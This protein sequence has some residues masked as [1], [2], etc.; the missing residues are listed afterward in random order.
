[1]AEDGFPGFR[2]YGKVIS[3]SV[4]DH[5]QHP[6]R[7]PLD[8]GVRI[9]DK[10]D[11]TLFKV[12]N[13]TR[14]V[15]DGIVFYFIKKAVNCQV[16]AKGIIR[17][18]AEGVIGSQY[19]FLGSS[20]VAIKIKLTAAAKGGNFNNFSTVKKNLDQPEASADK[21]AVSENF[22]KLARSRIS[23]YIKI[24]RSFTK[25]KVTD[26]SAYQIG[27]MAFIPQPVKDFEC[28]PVYIL[29]RNG[30]A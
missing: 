6:G 14:I 11:N 15:N 4:A 30:M 20:A 19:L 8:S 5:S 2:I 17:R 10:P 29:P 25:I 28:L 22:T 16:A 13:T 18:R 3:G 21:A 9:P 26:P 27:D 7:V 23:A 12:I 24:L 1:M